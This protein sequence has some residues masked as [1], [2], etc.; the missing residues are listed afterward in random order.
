MQGR[1]SNFSYFFI[2]N[3]WMN[4]KFWINNRNG[5]LLKHVTLTYK[6]THKGHAVGCHSI[7]FPD[8]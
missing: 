2:I 6:V 4:K 5:H 3:F 1:T 8:L 7:V